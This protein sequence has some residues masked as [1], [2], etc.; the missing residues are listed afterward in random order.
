MSDDKQA[1][2]KLCRL[3][4]EEVAVAFDPATRCEVITEATHCPLLG[5]RP[6]AGPHRCSA[7]DVLFQVRLGP[8]PVGLE[9]AVSA[10]P[11]N[12]HRLH[13]GADPARQLRS[14]ADAGG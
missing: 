7:T 14:E 12:E 5:L 9:E 11:R 13:P 10:I 2:A 8:A 1:K 6:D 3:E 4:M